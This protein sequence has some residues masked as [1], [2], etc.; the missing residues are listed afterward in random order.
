[1]ALVKRQTLLQMLVLVTALA[2]PCF[3]NILPD[4][5]FATGIAGWSVLDG[6]AQLSWDQ[7]LGVTDT[8]SLRATEATSGQSSIASPCLP[9]PSG[10]FWT[11]A[12]EVRPTTATVCLAFPVFY[13]GPNCTGDFTI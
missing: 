7:T 6:T 11:G 12:A 2:S 13:E 10:G 4:P 5:E 9:L 8:T 3:G 1:M